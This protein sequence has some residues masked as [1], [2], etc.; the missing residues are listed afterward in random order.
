MVLNSSF[1]K[2]V[3]H[4]TF[5]RNTVSFSIN[6]NFISSVSVLSNTIGGHF[7][8]NKLLTTCRVIKVP[9]PTYICISCYLR[10]WELILFAT[11]H[12]TPQCEGN[13]FLVCT[14]RGKH[15]HFCIGRAQSMHCAMMQHM[16]AVGHHHVCPTLTNTR[17][18]N[19]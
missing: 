15:S 7:W 1:G 17:L 2:M 16:T 11:V 5:Y 10:S 9:I 14:I 8:A 13:C 12:R 4:I 19:P 18:V 6:H 3:F